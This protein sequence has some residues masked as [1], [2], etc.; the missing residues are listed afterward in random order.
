VV[1]ELRD[2]GIREVILGNFRIVYRITPD[3]AQV[4][5]VYHAARRFGIP[6]ES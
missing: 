5:T 4:L 1:P 3:E 2:E 6:Q